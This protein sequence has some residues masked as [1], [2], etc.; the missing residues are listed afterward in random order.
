MKI[1][2][3]RL[4]F[5]L[6]AIGLS[7]CATVGVGGNVGGSTQGGGTEKQYRE[8]AGKLDA[9]DQYRQQWGSMTISSVVPVPAADLFGFD[10]GLKDADFLA[11]AQKEVNV[12]AAQSLAKSVITSLGARASIAQPINFSKAPTDKQPALPAEPDGNTTTTPLALKDLGATTIPM[13]L[14]LLQAYNDKVFAKILD[15]T[16][17]PTLP[18]GHKL[19]ALVCVAS[20][21]PGTQ[22][23]VGYKGVLLGSVDYAKHPVGNVIAK[24]GNYTVEDISSWYYGIQDPNHYV[25]GILAVLPLSDSQFIRENNLNKDASTLALSLAALFEAQGINIGADAMFKASKELDSSRDST[26][27]EA[28]TMAMPTARGFSLI[29]NPTFQAVADLTAKKSQPNYKLQAQTFP[30]VILVDLNPAEA[31]GYN[32][33]SV[34]IEPRWE[35]LSDWQPATSVKKSVEMAAK[36]DEAYVAVSNLVGAANSTLDDDTLKKAKDKIESQ[37]TTPAESS[38]SGGQ[39]G[40]QGEADRHP[41]SM[42]ALSVIGIPHETIVTVTPVAKP[43]APAPTEPKQTFP[44]NPNPSGNISTNYFKSLVLKGSLDS[45]FDRVVGYQ[46]FVD[47]SSFTV[48]KKDKPTVELVPAATPIASGAGKKFYLVASDTIDLPSVTLCG[49]DGNVSLATT[50]VKGNDSLFEVALPAAPLPA[51]ATGNHTAVLSV[52]YPQNDPQLIPITLAGE[53]EKPDPT[54]KSFNL[55]WDDNG[56]LTTVT[57]PSTETIDTDAHIIKSLA[58]AFTTPAPK[59][60]AAGTAKPAGTGTEKDPATPAPAKGT[61]K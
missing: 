53:K 17:H 45:L 54:L 13:R 59:A 8:A 10:P 16:G 29:F 7:S 33:L 42:R 4:L 26:V 22:T 18:K 46:Q 34:S 30:I 25:P 1:L 27:A 48:Q 38:S 39:S 52:V 24:T 12:S 11:N 51:F 35:P 50:A 15:L 5:L 37:Q 19:L 60:A 6:A 43:G 31:K 2:S 32:Y 14:A 21:V 23:S 58:P 55:K 56:K 9:V 20:C 44:I 57:V 47:I 3:T 36:L 40:G 61:G 49:P 41:G 28:A